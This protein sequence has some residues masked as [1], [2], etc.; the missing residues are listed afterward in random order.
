MP[1]RTWL[2][3]AALAAVAVP[4]AQAGDHGTRVQVF[5]GPDWGGY[6]PVHYRPAPRYYAPRHRYDGDYGAL[7]YGGPYLSFSYSWR[8]RDRERDGWYRHDGY[9][10]GGDLRY[11]GRRDRSYYR[12]DRDHGHPRYYGRGDERRGYRDGGWRR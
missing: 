4:A 2:A 6:A 5:L 10:R 11:D 1:T 8:D 12:G 7:Y 3:A 9:R